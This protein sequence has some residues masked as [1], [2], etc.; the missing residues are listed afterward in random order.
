MGML[1]GAGRERRR[2]PSPQAVAARAVVRARRMR[3]AAFVPCIPAHTW[4]MLRGKVGLEYRK[5]KATFHASPPPASPRLSPMSLY[6]LWWLL[7]AI[8]AAWESMPGT[9]PTPEGN[10]IP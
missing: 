7:G 4:G 5:N 8:A 3:L 6:G 2:G 10:L 9:R 1:L